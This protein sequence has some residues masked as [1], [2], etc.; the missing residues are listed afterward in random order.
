M[1]RKIEIVL[2]IDETDKLSKILENYEVLDKYK[3]SLLEDK[4]LYLI[5]LNVE[6][7]GPLLDELEKKLA[8][9]EG[10]RLNMLEVEATIPAVELEED[11]ENENEEDK[12]EDVETAPSDTSE[13]EKEDDE[14]DTKDSTRGLS[15]QELYTDLSDSINL[16]S[17][18][19]LM[20]VL[21]AIVAS[22]GVM[23]DNVAVIIGAMVIAPLLGPNVGMALAST[24]GDMEL[25]KIAIKTS[26]AGAGV[27]ILVALIAGLI[28]NPDTWPYEVLSRTS[29]GWGDITLA[30]ASGSAGTLA[31]TTGTSGAVIG[32]MIAVALMPPLV[33]VGILLGAGEFILA[34]GALMLFISNIICI[35]LAG[36]LTFIYQGVRPLNLW[37]E[38]KAKT[39][40][41]YSLF[42]WIF[43]LILLIV[44]IQVIQ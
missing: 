26:L 13:L 25:G 17:N 15:R 30:L 28:L 39:S 41:K 10:F 21:S 7:S 6:N 23:L 22:S 43:L 36:V 14:Q 11:S 3:I 4:A 32:V 35:N 9:A 27:S 2:P 29:V 44:G 8:F 20:C 5:T 1:L 40:R 34:G 37:E 38:K 24:L 18:Y 19:I 33:V 16:N 42:I 31:F 12:D